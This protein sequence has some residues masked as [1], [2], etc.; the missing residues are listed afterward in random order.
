MLTG[1]TTV[2]SQ[3]NDIFNLIF[4]YTMKGLTSL[5]F[6]YIEI[7]NLTILLNFT[8]KMGTPLNRDSPVSRSGKSNR[9]KI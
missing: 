2:E 6:Q 9:V 3:F 5:K 8:M 7:L 4:F 1:G